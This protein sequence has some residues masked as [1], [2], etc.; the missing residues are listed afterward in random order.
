MRSFV[1]AE[2]NFLFAFASVG[3]FDERLIAAARR[4]NASGVTK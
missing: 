3:L 1:G 4:M 2:L